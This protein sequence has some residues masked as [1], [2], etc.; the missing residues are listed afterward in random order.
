MQIPLQITFRDMEPSAAVE[1]DIREKAGK[2]EWF[3]DQIM[4]CRVVVSAPHGHHHKGNLYQ[5]RIDMTVPDGELLVTHEHH[6][7]DHSHEDVYVAI[8]DA[9]DAMK[10]QLEDY[11]RKRR[12]KVKKHEPPAHGRVFS[13]NSGE[14]YGRI[15]TPDERI[16]YFHRN[17][18]LDDAFNKLE[19]GS[20]VRFVEEMGERGPQASTVTLVGKHRIV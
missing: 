6:H 16:I 12:G 8:R 18:V 7:E 15:K 2:L 3:Y 17:S 4:S 14:D 9:F 19:V 10:R 5:V 11:A 20:E 13:L 1:A